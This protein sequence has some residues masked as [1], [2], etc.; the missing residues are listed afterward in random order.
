MQQTAFECLRTVYCKQ[1]QHNRLILQM[2][3]NVF[4][5]NKWQEIL[6]MV[7]GWANDRRLRSNRLALEWVMLTNVEPPEG[8]RRYWI[9]WLR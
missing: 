7:V 8:G 6:I 9:T 2:M 4:A 1:M 3:A 5:L